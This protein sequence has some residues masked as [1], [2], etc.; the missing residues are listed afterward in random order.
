MSVAKTLTF[1]IEEDVLRKGRETKSDINESYTAESQ[2]S[3]E[4]KRIFKV[5]LKTLK[6][7][8]EMMKERNA[9]P[10]VSIIA[11]STSICQGED[12]Q[13]SIPRIGDIEE[14]RLILEKWE[15]I[16]KEL[17]EIKMR[18]R[19]S[20]SLTKLIE[21]IDEFIS[22]YKLPKPVKNGAIAVREHL[23]EVLVKMM[24]G[25][26]REAEMH[27]NRALELALPVEALIRLKEKYDLELISLEDL[28]EVDRLHGRPVYTLSKKRKRLFI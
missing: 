22:L 13:V 15:S 16:I 11:R 25:K 19:G 5:F 28:E 6:I 1:K 20:M 17:K 12:I 21:D 24:E 14:P 4:L 9:A 8:E 23:K 2:E 10:L 27:I 26:F 3:G 18:G 7:N